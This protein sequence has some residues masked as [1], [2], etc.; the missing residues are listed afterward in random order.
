M[1]LIATLLGLKQKTDDLFDQ[2]NGKTI[3]EYQ[4]ELLVSMGR[5]QFE[6]L[7]DLGLN[8]PVRLA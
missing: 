1:K 3:S 7:Q 8:I 4:R 6:K 2:K 5:K